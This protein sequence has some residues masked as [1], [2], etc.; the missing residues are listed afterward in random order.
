[1]KR[2]DR[3]EDGV[4]VGEGMK[5]LD[6]KLAFAFFDV[7]KADCTVCNSS[8]RLKDMEQF[9]FAIASLQLGLDHP[10]KIGGDGFTFAFGGVAN[11][12]MSIDSLVILASDRRGCDSSALWKLLIA[13]AHNLG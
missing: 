8:A 10:E 1:M 3:L 6:K 2:R 7:K 11:G 4:I 5:G 12:G 13:R 9:V